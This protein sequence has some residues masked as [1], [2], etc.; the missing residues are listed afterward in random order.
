MVS[1]I[2]LS[3][4]LLALPLCAFAETA[5]DYIDRGAQKYIFGDDAGAKAEVDTGLAKFPEDKEL[6]K[7]TELFKNKKKPPPPP[8]KK[9]QDQQNKDEQNQQNQDQ[10]QQQQQKDQKNGGGNKQEQQ[11]PCSVSIPFPGAK[12]IGLAF[13]VSR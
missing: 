6:R 8:N 7:M 4:S 3:F 1:R 2:L 9:D 13:S 5:T 11:K 12:S 10:Q